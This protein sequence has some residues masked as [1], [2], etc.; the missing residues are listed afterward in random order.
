MPLPILMPLLTT[1]SAKKALFSSLLRGPAAEWY[2]STIEAATPW[3]GIRTNFI[4]RFSDGRNKFRHRLEVEHCVRRDGEEI[5]N[6]LHGIKKTVDKGWPDDMNGIARAQQNAEREAQARQRRQPYMDYSLRGL[7]PRYLQRKAQEYLMEHPNATWNDFSTHII[8]KDVS[9]Q[10]SSS[11]LN[12]EEQTKA[13]LASLGQEMKNLRTELQEHRVHAVEGTSKPVDPNQKGRQNATR[14]C[15]YCRT[16]G[17]TPSWCR[18]KIRDEELKKIENEKTAEKRVIKE[19]DQAMDPDNGVTIKTLLTDLIP[20]MGRRTRTVDDFWTCDQTNS[21]T[22]TMKIDRIMG[23][24][25]VKVELGEI[26]K[27]FLVHP[28][29]KDGTFLRE[30]L[31]VDLSRFSLEIRHLEDQMLTQSLV[32]LLTNRNFRKATIKHQR[33]WFV[34][35]PLMIALTYY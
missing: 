29:G 2:G 18:K 28:L 16:N 20:I 35:P 33:T 15:N 26:M 25:I 34:S 17:H 23:I 7:R 1:I 21:L 22:G 12:D 10:V 4:T 3:E 31:S 13:E 14:F 32:P 24:S 30:I 5:R 6:F 11:F 27:I 9:F 19:E 8:Q